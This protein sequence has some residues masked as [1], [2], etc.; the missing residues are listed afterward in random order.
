[1]N[2]PFWIAPA[3]DAS[4]VI[5]IG[6][7]GHRGVNEK[8]VAVAASLLDAALPGVLD[9]V[10]TTRSVGVYFD[11]MRTSYAHLLSLISG[12]VQDLAPRSGPQG[13]TID[14]PVCYGG[15]YGSD[16]A[17]IAALSGI[18]DQTVVAIHTATTYSV[19]ML[20]FAPGFAYLGDVDRRIAVPRRSQPRRRVAAGSV[21]L[22]ETQ[23]GI[24]PFDMPGGWNIIG[25]TMLRPYDLSRADPFLF[26][27]GDRVRF[28]AVDADQFERLNRDPV[29]SS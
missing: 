24:Y 2:A 1:M 25:R 21:G 3:G 26:A 19:Q 22:A 12:L 13:A 7:Q 11:P 17:D 14:V 23:T 5:A 10:P 29:A 6:D 28:H 18:D 20:G 16:L 15:V 9:V 27:Y 4:L 8:A